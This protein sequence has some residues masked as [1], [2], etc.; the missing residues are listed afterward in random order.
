MSEETAAAL[1]PNDALGNAIGVREANHIV[2][3]SVIAAMAVSWVPVPVADILMV[4]GVCVL[5][6][7]RLCEYY[8]TPFD[9]N[10]VRGA[11]LGLGAGVAPLMVTG[12]MSSAAKLIPGL[13]LLAGAAGSS[14]TAGGL[15]FAVGQVFIRHFE[16]NGTLSSFRPD[17]HLAYF[18]SML[19]KKTGP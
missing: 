16:G 6:V 19:T 3:N 12:A 5:M 13:G 7:R 1:Q 17:E 9:P 15:T 14:L 18:R 8:E 4:S 2:K 11:V 10:L